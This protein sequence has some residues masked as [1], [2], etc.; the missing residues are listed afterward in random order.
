M[1]EDIKMNEYQEP[2]KNISIFDL[3]FY[4]LEKWRWIVSCMLILA[5]VAGG[6][7]YQSTVKENQLEVKDEISTLDVEDVEKDGSQQSIEFY[8]HAIDETE[9]DLKIQED[10]M[11]NSVVMKL[12]PYHISTGTLSYYIEGSEQVGSVIAAYSTLI[13]GGRMAEELY[14]I[15]TNVP[16]EDLRYLVSFIN[17]T[18][19]VYRINDSTNVIYKIEDEQITKS[20]GTGSAVFQI[21]IRMPDSELGEY[22]L[23]RAKEIVE[24][25]TSQL[26]TEVAQY[27]LT[28]LASVQSEMI[29]QDIKEYQ[30]SIRLAYNTSVRNLQTLRTENETIQG[31]QGVKNATTVIK[32]PISSAIKFA[33]YGLVMGAFLSCIVLLILYL[34]GGRLQDTECFKEEFEMPLLGIVRLSGTKRK[35][36]GFI[37]NWVFGLRGGVYAKISY[38][39]QIKMAATNVQTAVDMN[40]PGRALNKIMLSGTIA[41]KDAASLCMQLASELQDVSLSSYS[42]IVFQSSALRELG[43]Y[44]GILFFEKRGVSDSGFIVQ[45]RKMALDRGVKVLGTIV[46]C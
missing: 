2:R 21:Q 15:D 20:S 6:Y 40:F 43:D 45:E 1:Q 30:S 41:E 12:D 28:L 26:Q 18:D 22:Y 8:E 27:K 46:V 38:E 35:V 42:Q 29:D 16:I 25:Y 33:V 24:E 31:M 5:V 4:C 36:F 7:K 34:L 37:D 9:Y 32:N 13:S 19:E 3:I 23:S 39:E 14:S 10:Y 44:D 17:S 11:K